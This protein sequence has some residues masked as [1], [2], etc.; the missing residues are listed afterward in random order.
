MNRS[1]KDSFDTIG[2]S[3]NQGVN[4]IN[5]EIR[6]MTIDEVLKKKHGYQSQDMLG[7][8]K[9]PDISFLCGCKAFYQIC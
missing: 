8:K 1:S 4:K 6:L 3:N 5:Q 7:R 2:K 9:N